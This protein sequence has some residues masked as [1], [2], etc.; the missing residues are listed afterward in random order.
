MRYLVGTSGWHYD[1]WR[2][3]FYPKD[4]AKTQW[5]DYYAQFF[6]TVEL[7][8]SFYRLPSEKAFTSWREESPPNFVFAVKVSRLITHLKKLRN[9]A[10]ALS[11]FWERARLLGDKLGPLLYQLPPN[12]HRNDK[13]LEEFLAILPPSHAHVFEFRHSSWFD[14]EVFRILNCY[15]AGFC[16]MDMV[17]ITCPL[18]VTA[19]FGY[20][21]FHGASGLYWGCYSD[22]ELQEWAKKIASLGQDLK[23]VYIYFNNDAEAYAVKNAITLRQLL[24]KEG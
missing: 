2:S 6:S 21:R 3:R 11:N 4:I 14:P 10:E 16:V 12:M 13:V 9:V 19:D 8:N 7:N 24:M 15:G 23:T 5:L 17:G 22:E 20:V 1:H 18:V